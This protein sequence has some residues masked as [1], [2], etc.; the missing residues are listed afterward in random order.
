FALLGAGSDAITGGNN[1]ADLAGRGGGALVLTGVGTA[2][3]TERLP[4]G[5]APPGFW[6]GTD[7]FNVS[8][9]GQAP[10]TLPFL[11]GAYGGHIGLTGNWAYWQ[12][13]SGQEHFI[14]YSATNARQAHT[15]FVTYHKGLGTGAY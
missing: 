2:G 10:Y 6:W 13:C 11:G 15:N 4:A 14:A 9:P 7:S 3:A 8:V 1:E 12:G 5:D